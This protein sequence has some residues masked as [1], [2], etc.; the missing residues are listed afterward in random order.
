MRSPDL[1]I[2]KHRILAID[3]MLDHEII[4]IGCGPV[5]FERSPYLAIFHLDLPRR[6]SPRHYCSLS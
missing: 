4:R 1:R 2:V 5:S 6:L 3:L